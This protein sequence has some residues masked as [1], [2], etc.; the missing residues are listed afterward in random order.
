MK[1]RES[2]VIKKS[3][4]NV[5]NGSSTTKTLHAQWLRS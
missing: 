3:Q 5:A 1:V 2:K 4:T